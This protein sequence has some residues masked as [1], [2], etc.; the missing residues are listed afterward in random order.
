[1]PGFLGPLAL[2]VAGGLAGSLPFALGSGQP[3]EE[4]QERML[5]RQ[6]EIQDEFEQKRAGRA[7]GDPMAGLVGGGPRDL[8]GLVA[9]DQLLDEVSRAAYSLNR[10]RNARSRTSDELE[11]IL[12]GQTA[13]IAA[14]QSERVLSP[15]EVIQMMEMMGG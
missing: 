13:R 14:L 2:A 3:S 6:L 15:L 8:A 7:G 1:M 9:E 10:A 12:E 5:R 4:E 11:R